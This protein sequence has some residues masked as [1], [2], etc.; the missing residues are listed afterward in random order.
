[1]IDLWGKNSRDEFI[2]CQYWKVNNEDYQNDRIVY[3]NEPSGFFRAKEVNSYN[4]DNQVLGEA[5][6]VSQYNVTLESHDD[7]SDLNV[8]DLVVYEGNIY[9]V[10]SCQRV[11]IKKQKMFMANSFSNSYFISLR[12]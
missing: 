9:R 7:L 2:E 6:M 11:P 10:D 1:M 12:R 8:N 4:E 3:E 5:F